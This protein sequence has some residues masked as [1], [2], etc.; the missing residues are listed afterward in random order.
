MGSENNDLARMEDPRKK[1]NGLGVPNVGALGQLIGQTQRAQR[2]FVPC[3]LARAPVSQ[4]M[5]L[6]MSVY[7]RLCLLP[8]FRGRAYPC[9]W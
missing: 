8:V 4:P 1:C 3:L 6:S 9:F 5:P 2:V 7:R